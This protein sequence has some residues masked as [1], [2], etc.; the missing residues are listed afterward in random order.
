MTPGSLFWAGAL[1]LASTRGAAQTKQPA[2]A[3]SAPTSTH[4]AADT[5]KA[6]TKG[7]STLDGLYTDEQASRGKDVYLNSCRSCHTPASHTGETFNKWW[8]GKHLSDLFAFVSTR[9]PKND[10]GSLAPEDVADV[11]AYLLKMNQMPVGPNELTADADSLKQYRIEAK[12]KT[13]PSPSTPK[14]KKP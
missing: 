10:P 12:P 3:H 8:R 1:A 7:P 11:M 6:K 9:M 13:S 2:A 5:A 4:A 14:R